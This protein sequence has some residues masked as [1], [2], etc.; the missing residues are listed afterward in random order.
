[1]ILSL[2]VEATRTTVEPLGAD[3]V[4]AAHVHCGRLKPPFNCCSQPEPESEEAAV[5]PSPQ[6]KVPSAKTQPTIIC[7]RMARVYADYRRVG[8]VARAVFCRDFSR[9]PAAAGT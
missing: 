9:W 3:A 5:P 8:L 6:R 2:V 4:I 1:L 7:V